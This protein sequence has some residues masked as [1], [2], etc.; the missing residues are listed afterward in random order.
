MERPVWDQRWEESGRSRRS[1]NS[2]RDTLGEK[3]N[4]LQWKEKNSSY[5]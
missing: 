3:K 2:N 1:E 5:K 4:P